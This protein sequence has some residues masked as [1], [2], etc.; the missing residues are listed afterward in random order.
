MLADCKQ[1]VVA[2][3]ILLLQPRHVLVSPFSGDV[4]ILPRPFLAPVQFSGT[5]SG[6]LH[7]EVIYVT[8]GWLDTFPIW[9]HEKG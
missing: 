3:F 9:D 5:E 1:F 7:R 6:C 8:Q 2:L 4:R